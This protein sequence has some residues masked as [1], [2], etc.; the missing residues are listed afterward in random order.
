VVVCVVVVEVVVVEGIPT[1]KK[2]VGCRNSLPKLR[3][4]G[5]FAPQKHRCCMGG[6]GGNGIPTSKKSVC[7]M[8]IYHKKIGGVRIL[9]PIFILGLANL[10]N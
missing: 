7:G 4:G 6:M 3:W 2:S 5:E 10:K 9:T 8:C 1:S